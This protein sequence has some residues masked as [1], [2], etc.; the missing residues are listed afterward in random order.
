MSTLGKVLLVD[1]EQAVRET[2]AR[3]LRQAGCQVVGF[4][5]GNLALQALETESFDLAYIDIHLPGQDGLQVMRTMRE[6][7]PDLPVVLFTGHATLQTAIEAMH[8]GAADYLLKPINP[9]TLISRTRVL[10]TEL[11]IEKRKQELR[12]QI[13]TLQE[14]LHRLDAMGSREPAQLEQLLPIIP[15]EE[16]FLRKSRLILDLHTRGVTL[17]ERVINL[18][19]TSFDYL[20][21]L[22]R[23]SPDVIP[24][25]ALVQEAQGYEVDR[26]EAIE[27][28]KWH[29]HV[30]REALELDP[31]QPQL[32]QN[33]RGLGY[34]LVLE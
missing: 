4:A 8:A 26:R 27:L 31:Q 30:L 25:Q 28:N 1:D 33:V 3:I 34:R 29:I 16:R 6:K 17:G 14:E 19:P 13:S 20:V 2:L 22:V 23:S 5:D 32:V 15:P 24:Y 21:A 10:L 7:N 9:E 18:T 11:G 12:Q